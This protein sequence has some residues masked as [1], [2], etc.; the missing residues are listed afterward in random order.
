MKRSN[1][2]SPLSFEYSIDFSPI[3]SRCR[4]IQ[5]DILNVFTG[6]FFFQTARYRQGLARNS[7][8]YKILIYILR[9]CLCIKFLR[10]PDNLKVPIFIITKV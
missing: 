9:F 2:T 8:R 3:F 4:P 6:V 1:T 7:I 5:I 10:F